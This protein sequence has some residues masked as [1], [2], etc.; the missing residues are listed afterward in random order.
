M[1]VAAGLELAPL[2]ADPVEILE[3]DA[4][5]ELLAG[6]RN[7]VRFLGGFR[8]ILGP[9]AERL[10]AGCLDAGKGA[11]LSLGPTLG[12]RPRHIGGQ[13]GRPWGFIRVQPRW[14]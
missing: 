8:R 6:G 4:G 12:F 14:P 13:L 7:P 10:L 1:V 3:S 11:G 2:T 9:M 5:Q